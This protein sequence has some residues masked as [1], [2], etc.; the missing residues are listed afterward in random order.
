VAPFFM[1]DSSCDPRSHFSLPMGQ[2]SPLQG[3]A[4]DFAAILY[5]AIRNAKCPECGAELPHRASLD[6]G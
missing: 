5:D 3:G 4:V 2:N 1:G 6:S